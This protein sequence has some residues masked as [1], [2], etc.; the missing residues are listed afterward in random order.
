M[1]R[2]AFRQAGH[3]GHHLDYAAHPGAVAD[4]LPPLRYVNFASR[5][6]R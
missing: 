4:Y 6:W 3:T 1:G 5:L 2:E